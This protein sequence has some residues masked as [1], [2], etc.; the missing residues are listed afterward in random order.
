MWSVTVPILH[1]GQDY[2]SFSVY[3]LLWGPAFL[4]TVATPVKFSSLELRLFR[5]F[6]P[7][8]GVLKQKHM[9]RI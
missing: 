2:K 6:P 8:P 4:T 7:F 3:E 1:W 9:K 5:N